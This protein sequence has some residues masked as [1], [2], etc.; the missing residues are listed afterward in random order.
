MESQAIVKQM[1]LSEDELRDLLNR[2][3]LLFKDLNE[4]QRRVF[5]LTLPSL[6]EALNSFVGDI[7]EE[8][9]LQF[10][11]DRQPSGGDFIMVVR[12][13]HCWDNDDEK[14]QS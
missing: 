3:A 6:H 5:S 2:F 14:E 4:A 11:Q 12:G 8:Q 7:T 1:G 10:L 13:K 9:L